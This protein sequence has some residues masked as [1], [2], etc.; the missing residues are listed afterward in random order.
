GG[1]EVGLRTGGGADGG[2]GGAEQLDVVVG[3]VGGVHGGRARPGQPL[4]GQQ[5]GGG[6]AV[7]RPARLVLPRLLGQ[8]EVQRAPGRG[9]GDDRQL[10]RGHRPHRVDGR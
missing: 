8:V 10:A 1:G 7:E 5:R 4:L 3:Q 6:A 2:G 9:V